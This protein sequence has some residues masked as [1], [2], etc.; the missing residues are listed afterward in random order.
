MEAQLISAANR[1]A[2]VAPGSPRYSGNI[3]RGARRRTCLNRVALTLL[4]AGGL[5]GSGCSDAPH[6]P[7]RRVILISCDTLRADHLGMYGYD[8]EVS[9]NLDAF[10]RD[11]VVFERAYGT[12]PHTN[13]ALSSLLTSRMPRE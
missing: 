9:P 1:N 5:W 12:A 13:P 7:V 2:P 3:Q 4:A 6:Q 8:R 11:A 10:A